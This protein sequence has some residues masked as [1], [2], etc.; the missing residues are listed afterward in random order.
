MGDSEESDTTPEVSW[1]TEDLNVDAI[2]ESDRKKRGL[3][4][5]LDTVNGGLC[6]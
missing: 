1:P 3:S 6:I 2:E 5:L 4:D